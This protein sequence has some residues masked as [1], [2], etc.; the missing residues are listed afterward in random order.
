MEEKKS[1]KG[2][3]DVPETERKLQELQKLFLADRNNQKIFE[4]YFLLLRKYTRSLTL[5]KIKRKNL[6][7]PPER[8]DE[9]CTDATLALLDQ[10]NN[11]NNPG[12]KVGSSFAGVIQ[13]KIIEAMWGHADDDMNSSLNLTFSD[14]K[15]SKEILDLVG[16]GSALPWDMSEYGKEKT[17]DNPADLVV[18]TSNVSFDEVKT[19]VEECYIDLPYRLYLRF[20]PWLVLQFRKPKTKN[21][22]SLFNR[23]YLTNKEEN[24]FD[25]LLLELHNRIS[26]HVV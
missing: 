13:F 14:D 7:L 11:P 17:S 12:W 20:V 19:L 21:I 8:V 6:F 25:M 16:S 9:I 5:K 15:D 1:K 3:S 24:A 10:Y 18:S 4:E 2:S 26:Q 22:Y 23:L